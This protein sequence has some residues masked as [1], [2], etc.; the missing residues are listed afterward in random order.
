MIGSF[1]EIDIQTRLTY[2]ER[3]D[4]QIFQ[5]D[6]F[7]LNEVDMYHHLGEKSVIDRLR[8]DRNE[9]YKILKPVKEIDLSDILKSIRDEKLNNIL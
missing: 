9:I 3:I 7:T 2:Y 5:K 6:M 8:N 1:N 4:G